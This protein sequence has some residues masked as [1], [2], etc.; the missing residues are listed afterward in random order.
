MT[1]I[2]Y[3]FSMSEIKIELRCCPFLDRVNEISNK[4]HMDQPQRQYKINKKVINNHN[5]QA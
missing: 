4:I 2:W 3:H 5:E 1:R